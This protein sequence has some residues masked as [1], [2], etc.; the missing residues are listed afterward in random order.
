MKRA[1]SA[2]CAG[3]SILCASYAQAA[4]HP[5]TSVV[6]DAASGTTYVDQVV[7][8]DWDPNN[9]PSLTINGTS[10]PLDRA[11]LQEIMNIASD[12]LY[13]MTE[14]KFRLGKISVYSNQFLDNADMLILNKDGR[15]NA[16]TSGLNVS[17]AR[18]QMFTIFSGAPETQNSMGRT[19]AHEFGHYLFGLLDEYREAGKLDTSDPGG[20]QDRDT[21]RN[22]VM[23]DHMQF[24]A[25]S[26]PSDYADPSQ[27][28]TA[29]F[30]WFGKSA[31]E[32]LVADPKTDSAL[33][34]N[35]GS[36]RMWFESFKNMAAPGV[37]TKPVNTTASRA[38]LQMTYM[39]GSRTVM[40]LDLT[41][42][43]TELAGFVKA[44]D[45]S[46]DPIPAG[47]QLAIM[48]IS[49]AQFNT[50]LELGPLGA[51]NT[52][53]ARI[54][55][56]AALGQLTAVTTTETGGLDKALRQAALIVSPLAAAQDAAA[57]AGA[58]AP[59]TTS[60]EV[61]Q[62]PIIQLFTTSSSSAAPDTVSALTKGG[63]ML[64]P[65]LLKKGTGGNMDALALATRG[66]VV[67]TT[68]LTD[69]VKK[70]VAAA[71]ESVGELVQTIV[72]NDADSLAAG[73]SLTL[74]VPIA[75]PSIDGKVT[76]SAYVEGNSGT[77]FSLISP[78]GA[79][80]TASNAAAT[81]ITYE[82][83][84]EEGIMSYVIPTN[85]AKRSGSWTAVL[86]AASAIADPVELEATVESQMTVKTSVAGGTLEDPRPPM[87][88]TSVSQPLAVKNAIVTVDVYDE[89]G[90]ALSSG[91][92][93][94]DDG[95][96]PD[97]KPGD[98]TY[99][100]SLAGLLP[101]SGEYEFV[102]H[103]ANTDLKAAYGTGGTRKSG[104]NIPDVSISENFLRDQSV[105]FDYTAGQAAAGTPVCTLTSNPI[106]VS[107]GSTSSLTATCSPTATSYLWSNTGFGQ[108]ISGG[109]VSPSSPT[110]YTVIGSNE[111]GS[112]TAAT[113]SIYVCNV[114]P[115]Q[116]YVGLTLPGTS[117]NDALY[118][119]IAGDAIDGGEGVD[120]VIYRCNRDSFTVTKTLSGWTV[121][122]KS[123]G[124][125]KLTNVER[126]QFGNQTLVL[127]SSG[128]AGQ[129][130][131]LYRST[132]NRLPD[133]AGLKFWIEVMEKGTTLKDV[134]ARF[135]VSPEFAVL[136]GATITNELF[137]TALYQN[138]LRR[139]PDAVGYAYWVNALNSNALSKVDVLLLFSE[140]PEN[141]AAILGGALNGID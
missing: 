28:Q 74:K 90:K 116:N 127:D 26:T 98:G 25:F 50:V 56:K 114:P 115:A 54:A 27:Q 49:G 29:Q 130:Y 124:V 64:N 103:V 38:S 71:H 30:R 109:T 105:Y 3:I 76:I 95:A 35:G 79:S 129:V 106:V 24:S 40:V 101:A 119:S 100:A 62:T 91:I 61:T 15:A 5:L 33:Q 126:I 89:S 16:S 136:Y 96:F 135:L 72:S 123:E 73:E 1:V 111:V 92:V 36:Q 88:I 132:F 31:W 137:V 113:A 86:A 68:K 122:S 53:P 34:K 70:S 94:R 32:T 12:T 120:T 133:N 19:V 118:G 14:G 46:I 13:T 21:P 140:S 57:K 75:S 60:V 6:Y 39:Q 44:A 8:I 83:D 48:A 85:V 139:Q 110:Q 55:A 7:A 22:T 125:D 131:R 112:G 81:G 47:S 59:L 108:S 128:N 134:A 102:V 82:H 117:G 67:Q 65:Q 97:V 58:P 41:V 11:Y 107:A 17:G 99:S 45:A 10:T 43:P 51:G 80:V 138:A 18:N 9:P 4:S 141:Q 84:V 87:I 37:A 52:D 63:V 2:I 66:R 104:A 121:S 93:L 42:S 23:N 77:T 20:P 78:S 69:L